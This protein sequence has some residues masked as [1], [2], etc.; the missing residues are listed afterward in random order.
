MAINKDNEEKSYISSYLEE[1]KLVEDIYKQVWSYIKPELYF[2]FWSL[3]LKDIYF[4][5]QYIV[6]FMQALRK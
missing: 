5:A 2:I 3:R 1:N 6:S 4:P